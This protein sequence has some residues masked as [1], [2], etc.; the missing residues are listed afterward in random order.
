MTKK[1]YLFRFENRSYVRSPEPKKSNRGITLMELLVVLVLLSIVSLSL[2][3]IFRTTTE[4]YSKGDARVQY[5][6]NARAALEIMGREIRAA[7]LTP[8]DAKTDIFYCIGL[9]ETVEKY[10]AGTSPWQRRANSAKDEFYFIAPLAND[11]DSDLCELGYWL[12]NRGTSDNKDD[13]LR[14][15]YVKD[16]RTVDNEPEFDG[17]FRTPRGVANSSDLALNVT[18]LQFEYGYYNH[19]SR[20]V[21]YWIWA[22]IWDSG[23]DLVENYGK[24]SD[25]KDPDGLPEAVKITIQV[26]DSRGKEMNTFSTVVYLPNVK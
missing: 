14:K 19:S 6:Q 24:D 11:A 21:K 4:S 8:P 10:P 20:R 16:D 15:F 9:D 22:N 25:E 2:F 26:T 1:F 3:T 12:D 7:L 13:T 18:N 5:Y 23:D 17:D